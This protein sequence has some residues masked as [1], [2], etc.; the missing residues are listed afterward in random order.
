MPNTPNYGWNVPTVDSDFDTWGIELNALFDLIDTEMVLKANKASPVFTGPV[1]VTGTMSVSGAASFP[2]GINGPVVVTGNLDVNGIVDV[3]SLRFPDGS[4]MT[5]ATTVQTPWRSNI[6][7]AGFK[8]SN[9]G[10]VSISPITGL[11]G[12]DV[13][14]LPITATAGSRQTAMVGR[15]N[16]GNGDA[17]ETYLFRK[18]A[19]ASWDTAAWRTQRV[20]DGASRMTYVEHGQHRLAFGVGDTEVAYMTSS[21]FYAP[22]LSAIG[23]IYSP[24]YLGVNNV[25]LRPGVD[26]ATAIQFQN[27]AG[28]VQAS[29][30]TAVTGKLTSVQGFK[31]PSLIGTPSVF[32]QAT[33]DAATAITFKNAA[34]ANI[35][36]VDTLNA[37]AF[38]NVFMASGAFIGQ[39]KVIIRPTVD[40]AGAIEFQDSTGAVVASVNTSVRAMTMGTGGCYS[41][42]YLGNN[43]VVLRPTVDS[44]TSI[45][46]QNSVGVTQASIDTA[47][48]G[49]L[50]SVQG[51]AG[52]LLRGTPGLALR[53]SGDSATAVQIQNTAGTAQVSIDTTGQRVAIGP[54]APHPTLQLHLQASDKAFGVNRLT[55]AQKTALGPLNGAMVFD[56]DLQKLSVYT[57]SG[58]L[59]LV[60]G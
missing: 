43:S 14:L 58:W 38:S 15:G 31:G 2:G 60:Y 48:T 53:P 13:A 4:S 9:A 59:N 8:L 16:S 25:V 30:D 36:T 56:T 49:Q 55:T 34:G 28:V 52:P 26:S 37:R 6:D 22:I 46:F 47:A 32:L 44:G 50:N 33:T 51:F 35:L 5:T 18:A 11:T 1:T 19:G 10:Q 24:V 21:A 17:M 12:L 7:G 57:S 41:H 54:S 29:I 40:G 23:S 27:M 45:Q 42:V 39:P 3:D 20:V